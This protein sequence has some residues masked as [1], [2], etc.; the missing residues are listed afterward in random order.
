M[1]ILNQICCEVREPR[2]RTNHLD[3]DSI[4]RLGSGLHKMRS[5]MDRV[6]MLCHFLA[7]NAC[8]DEET[9]YI[10]PMWN[11]NSAAMGVGMRNKQ[12]QENKRTIQQPSLGSHFHGRHD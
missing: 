11:P 8:L 7:I 6:S 12:N 1:Y 4:F 9:E 2:A 3:L 5:D 10:S